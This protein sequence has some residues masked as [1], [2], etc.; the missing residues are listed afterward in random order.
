[1]K[2][3]LLFTLVVLVCTSCGG[4]NKKK[5]V[6]T[7]SGNPGGTV[8]ADSVKI[9]TPPAIPAIM[10]DAEAQARWA[11]EHWWDKFDFADTLSVAR[12]S[13]YAEQAFVD[14]DYGVLMNVPDD[15]AGEALS[16]LFGRAA[17]NGDVFWK[18][19]GIAEKYL[20][21]ANSPVRNEEHY[22]HVLNALLANPAL[23]E[24]ERIRPQE[25]LRL[26]LKNRVGDL[27]ADFR[28]TLAS[29]ATGTLYSL[30]APYTLLFFNNPGCSTCR[31]MM[32]QISSTPFL[33]SRIEEGTLAV[34]AVYPDKDLTAW[35]E[36]LT[37]MPEG[38]IVS[39]DA[40]QKIEDGELYDLK[41]IPTLYLL[42][43]D[44]RVMLKD[45]MSIP[46]IEQTIYNDQAAKAAAN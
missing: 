30:R 15:M 20:F 19:A 37:Q 10:S 22:I 32:D 16:V 3:A 28:Y 26:A 40:A 46:Q 8:T 33:R 2:K 36:Y 13:D 21:D 9:Y 5:S 44:K 6:E 24:W 45:V 35:R 41:A 17:A 38:W 1:M 7:G 25:Q 12:W 4:Q 27:A 14:F 31:D 29:G 23:D 18:F 34:L 11:V 39:Y 43:R 42:D